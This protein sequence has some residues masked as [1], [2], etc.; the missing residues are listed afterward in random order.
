MTLLVP[1]YCYVVTYFLPTSV[2][3]YTTELPSSCVFSLNLVAVNPMHYPTSV[4]IY[5]SATCPYS[6]KVELRHSHSLP[7]N[8]IYVDNEW[9]N[10]AV[11]VFQLGCTPSHCSL[12][13]HLALYTRFSDWRIG[14][15]WS[16]AWHPRWPDVIQW[17]IFF[18]IIFIFMS[19]FLMKTFWRMDYSLSVW[20]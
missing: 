19:L 20:K 14:G 18:N 3:P 7:C 2:S 10:T 5:V 13:V 17:L 9:E 12:E 6:V 15:V 4:L 8:Y 16:T 11:V 1:A